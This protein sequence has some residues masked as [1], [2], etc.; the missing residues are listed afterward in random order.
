VICPVVEKISILEQPFTHLNG[1]PKPVLWDRIK[2][3]PRFATFSDKIVCL[4]LDDSDF[5]AGSEDNSQ[6]PGAHG[7]RWKNIE[8]AEELMLLGFLQWNNEA[9]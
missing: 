3:Q 8:L 7:L 5:A 6:F 1:H 9:K 4:V 2:N